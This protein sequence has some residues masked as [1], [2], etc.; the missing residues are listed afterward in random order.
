[1]ASER[2]S[3][4]YATRTACGKPSPRS[5]MLSAMP[6]CPLWSALQRH[7]RGT[8]R[9]A[10]APTRRVLAPGAQSRAAQCRQRSML[11]NERGMAGRGGA[12]RGM[13]GHGGAWR[14]LLGFGGF[15]RVF[16]VWAGLGGFWRVLARLSGC[17]RPRTMTPTW[18]SY[19][20]YRSASCQLSNSIATPVLTPP[21]LAA[22]C[23]F[24]RQG[25]PALRRAICA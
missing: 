18:L 23:Q 19:G 25:R 24:K 20:S 16:W 4:S 1:M 11:L 6:M 15:W 21:Y 17:L 5:G 12:W 3:G 22:H 8:A 9:P 2:S 10:C 14:G 13:A 7:A